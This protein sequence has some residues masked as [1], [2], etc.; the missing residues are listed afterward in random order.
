MPDR[1]QTIRTPLCDD[2]SRP[3]EAPIAEGHAAPAVERDDEGAA[4]MLPTD[5]CGE[6]AAWIRRR[7]EA[8]EVDSTRRPVYSTNLFMNGFMNRFMYFGR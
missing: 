2:K 8:K 5:R 6:R 7:I 3:P 1:M 4:G